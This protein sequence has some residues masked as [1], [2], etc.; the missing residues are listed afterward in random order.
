MPAPAR[1]R[2]KENTISFTY[3]FTHAHL[4]VK[5]IYELLPHN[6]QPRA[7]LRTRCPIGEPSVTIFI[8]PTTAPQSPLQ[9]TLRGQ[10][11]AVVRDVDVVGNYAEHVAEVVGELLLILNYDLK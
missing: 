7:Y 10:K 8:N 11:G 2:D 6:L 9:E 3:G 4:S 1:Y 5:I